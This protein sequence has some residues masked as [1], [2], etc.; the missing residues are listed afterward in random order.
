MR[1]AID[2]PFLRWTGFTGLIIGSLLGVAAMHHAWFGQALTLAPP[3]EL[4]AAPLHAGRRRAHI[5]S[6]SPRASAERSPNPLVSQGLAPSGDRRRS[7]AEPPSAVLLDVPFSSQAPFGDWSQPWQDACEETSVLMAMAWL[8]GEPLGPEAVRRQILDLIDWELYHFGYHRDTAIRETAKLFTRYFGYSRVRTAYDITLGDIKR[9]LS[10]G[11]LVI[12]PAAGEVLS[13]E[14]PYYASP[15]AYH[16]VVVRGYDDARAQVIVND[17]GTRRGQAFRYSYDL[18]V[19]A[20]HDWTGD[21]AT[22]NGGQ[23]GMVVVSRLSGS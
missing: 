12:V 19:E 10:A 18:F 4:A 17:P 9:E 7:G 8:R 6:E 23:A 11:N 3:Q 5:A 15:P 13:R 2:A 14:N 20:I 21:E 22:I 16:M 1:P